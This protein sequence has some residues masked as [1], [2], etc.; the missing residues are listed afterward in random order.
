MAGC[1]AHTHTL[2]LSHSLTP[3][4]P[5]TRTHQVGKLQQQV[6]ELQHRVLDAELHADEAQQQLRK[7]VS[8]GP[9]DL[10]F[11][12]YNFWGVWGLGYP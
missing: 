9:L 11:R 5:H 6:D 8:A 12:V 1:T 2:S 10:C 4:P 3:L 7:Q